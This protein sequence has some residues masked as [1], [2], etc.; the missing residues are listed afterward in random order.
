MDEYANEVEDEIIEEDQDSKEW[1]KPA[2]DAALKAHEIKLTAKFKELELAKADVRSVVGDV[3][4]MDSAEDIY[5]FALKS[6]KI[7]FDGV[8]ELAGLKA[9]FKAS[10]TMDAVT[11]K[12][13]SGKVKSMTD[14]FPG[15]SRF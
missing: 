1:G 14:A 5:K 15:L 13:F 3:L 2:M 6:K 8:N 4:G 11:H 9:V 10:L 7:A 12:T